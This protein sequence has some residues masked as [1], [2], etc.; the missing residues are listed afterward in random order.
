MEETQIF[1]I[2]WIVKPWLKPIIFL[3]FYRR[4]NSLPIVAQSQ[5]NKIQP[6]QKDPVFFRCS[7]SSPN[8]STPADLTSSTTSATDLYRVR[9]SAFT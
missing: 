1:S 8:W 3:F 4:L 7:V 5:N 2:D 6:R 9:A